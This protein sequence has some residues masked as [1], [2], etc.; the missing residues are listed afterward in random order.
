M[1]NKRWLVLL[2]PELLLVL[3]LVAVVLYRGEWWGAPPPPTAESKSEPVYQAA[4]E[5]STTK[6]VYRPQE[7]IEVQYGGM[8]GL[9]RDW[10]TLVEKEAPENRYRQWFYTQGKANGSLRF[11]GL[12]P[13]EYE[14]RAYFDWPRGGYRV[15]ARYPLRVESTE[16]VEID[17]ET[18]TAVEPERSGLRAQGQ[19]LFDGRSLAELT[20]ARPRFWF[21]DETRGKVAEPRYDY[22]AG[23]LHLHGLGEGRMGVQ[24][25]LNLNPANPVN[26]PGDLYDWSTFQPAAEEPVPFQIEM[27]RI[28]HL[29]APQD[30][31]AIMPGWGKKCDEIP[32]FGSPVAFAWEPME[33]AEYELRIDRLDCNRNYNSAGTAFQRTLAESRLS[34]Q[35]PP[36]GQGEVYA[37]HLYARRNGRRVG[38]LIT[39]GANGMGWDYRFRVK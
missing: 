38:Q 17:T 32:A 29:T 5:V 10:I 7:E 3:A 24:A 20:A 33:G 2:I 11:N 13:G 22:R 28:L 35:L 16:A 18:E 23:V 19:V 27:Q 31:G 9:D 39:H 6:P 15:R 21:R 36:S 37:L 1:K 8:P 25:T 26:Y 30:N 34:L 4:P 12:A 14:V